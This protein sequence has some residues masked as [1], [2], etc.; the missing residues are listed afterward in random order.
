MIGYGYGGRD[1]W[2]LAY[3][4]D[5][6]SPVSPLYIEFIAPFHEPI[7]ERRTVHTL[8]Y[9]LHYTLIYIMFKPESVSIQLIWTTIPICW[10]NPM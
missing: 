6:L 9:P 8:K 1:I 4:L 10:V 7:V 5:C 2:F 3:S